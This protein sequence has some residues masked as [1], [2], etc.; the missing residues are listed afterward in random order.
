MPDKIIRVAVLGQGRS[1][2]NIHVSW[3]R[4][5]PQQYKVV[6]VADLMNERHE[7]G[8]ELGAKVF[9]DYRELLKDRSLG[10]DF[11]VNALPS[12][13]HPE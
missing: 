5:A 1:G 8:T 7:A 4:Q 2:Y 9:T 13:L 12:H 10:I 11:V 3:L 6:A